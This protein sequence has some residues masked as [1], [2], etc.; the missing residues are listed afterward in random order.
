MAGRNRLIAGM[1]A[2]GLGAGLL[3]FGVTRGLTARPA[4]AT[5][6]FTDRQACAGC[7]AGISLDSVEVQARRGSTLFILRGKLPTS[8]DTLKASVR[9]VANDTELVL[10]SHGSQNA[11]EVTRALRGGAPIAGGTVGAS[12]QQG[13]LL[14]DVAPPLASPVAFEVG[15][16]SG[17]GYTGRLPRSGRLAWAG[18]GVSTA[19]ASAPVSSP[20]PSP[21]DLT[22]VVGACPTIPGGGA[23]PPISP[24]AASAARPHPRTRAPMPRCASCRLR[25]PARCWRPQAPSRWWRW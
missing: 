9:L 25:S 24:S 4:G 2:T 5:A 13:A 6:A 17:S 18:R 16:W 21:D 20:T 12:I 8:A 7:P 23:V 1:L 19:L 22:A 14:I 15:F 3:A 10:T 11:F